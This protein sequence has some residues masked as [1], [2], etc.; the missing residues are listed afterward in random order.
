MNK[1][2]SE[3]V[4]EIH[5]LAMQATGLSDFGPNDYRAPME[6]L[7]SQYDQ[8][9]TPYTEIGRELLLGEM[10]GRLCGRLRAIDGFK[11]HPE[12]AAAPVERPL[13][14]IGMARSGTTALHRLLAHDPQLQ[15]LPLWLAA[16]PMPRPPLAEWAD[17]PLYQATQ[18]GV[19]R[20][21]GLVPEFRDIHPVGAGMVDECRVITE[22]T[23]W[24]CA[25]ASMASAP[26]YGRWCLETDATYAYRYHRQVLG[27]I[28]GGDSR[29]WLLKCPIHIWGLDALL[30]VYPDA[31]IVYTHRRV[32]ESL[33]STASMVWLLRR[34]RQEGITP[35]QVGGHIL[36]LWG[37][38]LRKSEELRASIDPARILDISLHDTLSDPLGTVERI[39][40]NF[41]IPVTEEG[42]AAMRQFIAA[43]PKAGHGGHRY[44]PE[45]FG[46]TE[47]AVADVIGEACVARNRA[48][49]AKR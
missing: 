49:C 35:E 39:Y 17:S 20:I 4:S 41:D 19:D 48:I 33:G 34:M 18:Q 11:K 43:D 21:Y 31:N 5:E 28:A 45:F 9:K 29:R 22:Q 7:L 38:A 15:S 10:V 25:A 30:K 36:Q 37:R 23:F 26:D 16:S 46:L 24:A 47:S 2:F 44:T 1:Q 32:E 3:R 6:H 42:M 13:I 40:R 8:E 27:L 12:F 14:I